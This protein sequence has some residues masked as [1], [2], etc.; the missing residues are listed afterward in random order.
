MGANRRRDRSVRIDAMTRAIKAVFRPAAI[1]LFVL[2]MAVTPLSAF[3]SGGVFETWIPAHDGRARVRVVLQDQTGLV[4]AINASFDFDASRATDAMPD[5]RVL[6][7]SWYG[8]CGQEYGL[9]LTFERDDPG[10]LVRTHAEA[11]WCSFDPPGYGTIAITLWAP[12]DAATVRFEAM[13]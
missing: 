13:R 6:L 8:D 9:N 3:V 5:Q 11:L 10:Y 12:V 4:R 2:V 1:A 7:V